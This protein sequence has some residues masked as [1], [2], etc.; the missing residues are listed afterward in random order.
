MTK[1]LNLIFTALPMILFLAVCGVCG[2]HQGK[3]AAAAKPM[4]A[5]RRTGCSACGIDPGTGCDRT[6]AV[7]GGV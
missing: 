5:S 4:A 1:F 2:A 6:V 7:K 3:K